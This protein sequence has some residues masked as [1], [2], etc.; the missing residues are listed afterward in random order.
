[1]H[2]WGYHAALPRRGDAYPPYADRQSAASS[3][4]GQ[5]RDQL[6]FYLRFPRKRELFGVDRLRI[7]P[8]QRHAGNARLGE[9]L[10]LSAAMKAVNKPRIKSS[11]PPALGLYLEP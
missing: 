7:Y 4:A 2:A 11:L 5:R 6:S 3:R 10:S 1:A 8:L 9:G